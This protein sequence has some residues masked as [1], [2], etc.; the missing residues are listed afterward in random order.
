MFGKKTNKT[1]DNKVNTFIDATVQSGSIEEDNALQEKYDKDIMYAAIGKLS[2]D[3]KQLSELQV[4]NNK[5]N[6]KGELN[7]DEKDMKILTADLGKLLDDKFDPKFKGL[8]NDIKDIKKSNEKA[9]VGADC[10]ADKLDDLDKKFGTIDDIKKDIDGFKSS[11]GNEIKSVVDSI[12]SMDGK[13]NESI[14]SMDEKFN[15]SIS[16]VDE[17]LKETC[18]G[19]DCV[20]NRF[21][22]EDDLV[23]CEN[24]KQTFSLSKNIAGDK[25]ICPHCNAILNLD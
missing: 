8:E 19:I 9:C 17:K 6:D 2:S 12:S 25:A 4:L 10:F 21:K 20:N 18:E 7:M 15:E 5:I 14:S 22:E 13:F 1:F 23:E 3:K 16:N 24:C 11:M